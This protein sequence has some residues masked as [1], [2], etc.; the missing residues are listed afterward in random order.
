MKYKTVEEAWENFPTWEFD[1]HWRDTLIINGRD[2]AV[3]IKD[4]KEV[5]N[6]RRS[7][8]AL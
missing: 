6:A 7:Q 8:E 5:M 1:P 3:W 2:Y 4:M